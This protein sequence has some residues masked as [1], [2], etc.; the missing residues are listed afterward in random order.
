MSPTQPPS[1]PPPSREIAQ[2]NQILASTNGLIIVII[3]LSAGLMI[4][5]LTFVVWMLRNLIQRRKHQKK[6]HSGA[7]G[8]IV[9]LEDRK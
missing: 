5:C 3:L 9:E 4:I 8:D 2:I 1:A 6:I 7:Q